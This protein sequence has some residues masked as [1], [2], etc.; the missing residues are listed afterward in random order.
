M[1]KRPD[2]AIHWSMQITLLCLALLSLS[3]IAMFAV[4][5]NTYAAQQQRVAMPANPA[6]PSPA[7]SPSPTPSPSPAPSPSPTSDLAATAAAAIAATATETARI[8][9]HATATAA[10]ATAAANAAA[11]A[12]AT[13]AAIPTPTPIPTVAPTPIPTKAPVV[14]PAQ[15]AATAPTAPLMP[16]ATP[17]PTPT[18]LIVNGTPVAAPTSSASIASQLLYNSQMKTTFDPV[19]FIIVLLALL[20]IISAVYAYIRKQGG[21]AAFLAR[22]NSSNNATQSTMA[23]PPMNGGQPDMAMQPGFYAQAD[24][25]PAPDGY[26]PEPEYAQQGYPQ[27]DYAPQG[28][29]QQDYQQQGYP[30]Q[31]YPQPD[32]QQQGYPQQGYPQQEYPQPDY[33]PAVPEQSTVLTQQAFYTQPMYTERQAEM[34]GPAPVQ[35]L[36]PAPQSAIPDDADSTQASPIVSAPVPAVTGA[37]SGMPAGQQLP[38]SEPLASAPQPLEKQPDG[39]PD[40]DH[41]NTEQVKAM[42]RQAQMGL[43]V[44]PDRE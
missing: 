19:A 24:Y 29:P 6:S 37:A 34:S 22:G 23:V 8:S 35:P 32:Y 33:A 1:R 20:G 43:F 40:P 28:Y 17:N 36:Q 21:L 27:Q 15:Q 5:P 16:T 31:D 13:A 26:Y 30:Q 41:P 14:A 12:T 10:K 39:S 2:R 7:P 9:Q 25:A 38:V 3:L 11:N 42:M 44:I 4:V 18:P